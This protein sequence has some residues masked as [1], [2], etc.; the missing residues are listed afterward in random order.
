M[1]SRETMLTNIIYALNNNVHGL[2][3]GKRHSITPNEPEYSDLKFSAYTELLV[4][5]DDDEEMER[6]H[7]FWTS[8]RENEGFKYAEDKHPD[9]LMEYPAVSKLLTINVYS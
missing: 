2:L 1:N 8:L 5:T 7:K 6:M 3:T 9:I 4:L